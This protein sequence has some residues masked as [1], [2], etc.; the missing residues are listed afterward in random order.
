[1]LYKSCPRCRG[2]LI[3]ER[4]FANEPPD[5]ACLQCGRHLNAEERIAVQQGLDRGSN[6]GQAVSAERR[7][8]AA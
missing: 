4:E 6:H 8:N 3:V 1:M 5:I 7:S 2:D